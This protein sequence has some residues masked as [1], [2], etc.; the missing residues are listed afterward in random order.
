[1]QLFDRKGQQRA[2]LRLNG[3][4]V[5]SLRLYDANGTLRSAMSFNLGTLEPGFVLFDENGVGSWLNAMDSSGWL[6][7]ADSAVLNSN[8]MLGPV[9]DEDAPHPHLDASRPFL[10]AGPDRETMKVAPKDGFLN[11]QFQSDA[12]R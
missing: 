6:N 9:Y 1:M 7:P 3:D 11:L 2:Q 4:D 10:W 8:G 5:P 12:N